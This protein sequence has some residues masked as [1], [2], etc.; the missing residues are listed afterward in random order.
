MVI[1]PTETVL[2]AAD[3]DFFLTLFAVMFIFCMG[4]AGYFVYQMPKQWAAS[5][6]QMTRQ[7]EE[8][9]NRMSRQWEESMKLLT[10]RFT[11]RLTDIICATEGL[12]KTTCD[13]NKKYEDHDSQ[14]KVILEK[15]KELKEE[16]K[17]IKM[18]LM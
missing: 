5:T 12:K 15:T 6:A 4:I 7:W 8:S 9:S 17:D 2:T 10:E 3:G 18:G 13:L 11:D 1:D 14:A 16:L